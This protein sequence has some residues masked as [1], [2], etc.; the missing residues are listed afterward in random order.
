MNPFRRNP[1]GNAISDL[2]ARAS[3]YRNGPHYDAA[4]RNPA[5]IRITGK[6][7]KAGKSGTYTIPK[8]Q[9]TFAEAYGNHFKPSPIL[10]DATITFGG[11]FGLTMTLEATIEC[12][13]KS[14]FELVEKAFLYP[15]S[16]IDLSFGY[17]NPRPSGYSDGHKF[18]GFRTATYSFNTTE[19]GF[20]IAKF[21][22]V[23]PSEAAKTLDM[24]TSI[25]ASNLTYLDGG[26]T[27]KVHG[28]A[29]LMAHD[30]QVNGQK[31][32]D[33]LADGETITSF[34]SHGYKESP[35]ACV[36]FTSD[37]LKSGGV[38]ANFAASM[39]A[40]IGGG[41]SS[42]VT[43]SK[44]IPYYTL[45]YL[46]N[47]VIMGQLKETQNAGI[48]PKDKDDFKKV[49]I[50]FHPKYSKSIIDFHIQSGSPTKI[51]LLGSSLGDYLNS[52]GAGKNFE[53]APAIKLGSVKCVTKTESGK[54]EIDFKKIL[55][56]R[57]TILAALGDIDKARPQANNTDVKQFQEGV[58][59]VETF[60]NNVFNQ[61]KAATGG[62][63]ALRLIQNPDEGD[64]AKFEQII[65]D[66]NYGVADTL[67]CIVF[68]PIDGDGSTRTCSVSSGVG[69][70]EY[71][72]GMF[73]GAM[74]KG[75]SVMAAKEAYSDVESQRA[76]QYAKEVIKQK[77]IVKSPGALGDSH[78]DAVQQ[79]AL[80]NCMGSLRQTS[81]N[82]DKYDLSMYPGMGID[83]SLD[84][85][86]GFVP[87]NAISSTQLTSGYFKTN[88]FF[89]KQVVH[90]FSQSD[91]E[92]R[93]SGILSF[94]SNIKYNYLN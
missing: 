93:I 28:I 6:G 52:K 62:A 86:W 55:I 63:I 44:N 94:Y 92:T 38:M 45:E 19:Q 83:V 69:S 18:T 70:Q 66:E 41:T 67:Q 89:V 9:N 8:E 26:K 14:D 10:S 85:V 80:M 59:N 36:V 17:G 27:Y 57:S 48:H 74:R 39:M 1:T 58:I 71:K 11:D 91:W 68:D 35:G 31:S 60:L 72:A 53:K 43:E 5:W 78:F 2:K 37:H 54:N 15:G 64:S 88:Y 84:G 34:K 77:E 30:A 65:I 21:K 61:I 56:E 50:K 51:L 40:T 7:P 23:A 33:E 90:T 87:G 47:R 73:A 81:Q 42:E 49:S 25:F 24:S 4:T 75:D 16:I 76:I 79:D 32:I 46:V 3:K 12:H 29:E 22:A 13:L 82:S 20:W